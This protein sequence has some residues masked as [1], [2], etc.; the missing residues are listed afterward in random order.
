MVFVDLNLVLQSNVESA[1][2][3]CK[4]DKYKCKDFLSSRISLFYRI[5]LRMF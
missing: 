1:Y 2:I 5:H 3:M 4:C